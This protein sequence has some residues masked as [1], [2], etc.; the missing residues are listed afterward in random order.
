MNARTWSAR[1]D[2]GS[3]ESSDPHQHDGDLPLDELLDA[4]FDEEGRLAQIGRAGQQRTAER[5]DPRPPA[6]SPDELERAV[7]KLAEGLEAIERQ[8]AL[9]RSAGTR[10]VTLPGDE[11]LEPSELRTSRDHAVEE[12]GLERLE[13]RLQTLSRRLQQRAEPEPAETRAAPA[14]GTSGGRASPGAEPGWDRDADWRVPSATQRA[15]ATE[16]APEPRRASYDAEMLTPDK[17]FTAETKRQFAA[18]EAR[19][20]ALQHNLGDAQIEPVRRELLELLHRVEDVGRDGRS[21]AGAV[22]EVSA[23]LDQMETKLN[24]ARNL[25]GNRLSELQDRLSGIADRIGG[26]E[27]EVPGFDAL[28]QNQSAI[29]ERFDRMEGLVQHIASPEE[30]LERVDGLRRHMQAIAS[31]RDVVRIE[32]QISKLAERLDALPGDRGALERMENQ[33]QALAGE[34]VEARRQRSSGAAELNGRLAELSATLH[35][36]G[37][38][39]RA[40]DLTGLEQKLADIGSRLDDER[41]SAGAA[42]ARLEERLVA[43]GAAVEAEKADAAVEMLGG[44]SQRVEG[45]AAA[46]EAQDAPRIRGDLQSLGDKLDQLARSLDQQAERLSPRLEP[47]EARL[48]GLQTQLQT[49]SERA[50]TSTTEFGHV[51]EKVRE[52]ADRVSGGA[53]EDPDPVAAR[54][55]IIEER[56]TA[57]AARGGPDARALQTQLEAVVSRLEILKG[58]SIDPARINELFDRIDA[59]MRQELGSERFDKLEE[60]LGRAVVPSERFDQ[61]EKRLAE[62]VPAISEGQLARL[63]E[64]IDAL[65]RLPAAGVAASPAAGEGVT[66]EDIAE[67]RTD[68][69]ALR[70][71]LRS[72]PGLG[73]GEANLG[74]VLKAISARLN[75]LPEERPATAPEL[76]KQIDRLAQ[77]F[78]EPSDRRLALAHIETSLKGIE[79]RLEET[80]RTLLSRSSS[81]ADAVSGAEID[82]VTGLARALSDDVTQLKGAAEAS[83]KRNKEAIEALQGTMEAVVKRMAFLER[84][85]EPSA[86]S[87]PA[88]AEPTHGERVHATEPAA[89]PVS[90]RSDDRPV[91]AAL[92]PPVAAAM[93]P[94]SLRAESLRETSSGGLFGR[95]TSRELL[96]RAT[97]GRADSFS[98]DAD[99][100][101]ETADLPL[102]PGTDAPIKSEL[103]GAPSSDTAFMAGSRRGRAAADGD[104]D[105]VRPAHDAPERMA[106]EDFLAAARRAAKEAAAEAAQAEHEAQEARRSRGLSRVLYAMRARR[107]VLLMAA[108]LV[109]LGFAAFQLMRDRIDLGDLA[110]T[111]ISSLIAEKTSS[112]PGDTPS[113]AIAPPRSPNST[114]S[115]RAAADQTSRSASA[116]GETRIGSRPTSTSATAEAAAPSAPASTASIGKAPTA[117]AAKPAETKAVAALGTAQPQPATP[118]YT[119]AIRT[120]DRESAASRPTIAAPQQRDF[121][122]SLAMPLAPTSL[123]V[124]IGPAGLRAA[125]LAGDPVAAFEVAARFAEGRGTE[126]DPA[127]AIQWYTQAA[128]AGL[129]PAQ[130]RLGS[131]YEKG[132]GVPKDARAAAD[133]YRRAAEAGNVKAMHNLAVLYA[134]GASGAPNLARAA[135]LFR[136]A[137]RHGVRDSQFNLAILHARGLGVPVDMVE[138]YKWFAVAASS[139]DAEALKRRDV[140]GDALSEADLAKA[141]AAAAAFEPLPLISEANDVMLPEGGWREDTTSLDGDSAGDMVALVQTL[142]AQRGYDPGPADGLLGWKTIEAISLF[143]E[144]AGLPRTGEVDSSLVAALQDRPT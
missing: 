108:L 33:L 144:Q 1:R 39:G 50:E 41:R 42:L 56:L 66:Q 85:A 104:I 47:L 76:E 78:E 73:E 17:Q 2:G 103:A 138:A 44:L 142:L 22:G 15:D 60:M 19:V 48:Q 82:A 21:I 77:L 119:G 115:V 35:Q 137:A 40:P 79:A 135:E 74:A 14:R 84:D 6:L 12:G 92:Q 127:A 49:L 93:Q 128:E 4:R 113:A 98:P 96:K 20:E 116:P 71:E 10:G 109:A 87:A 70:R 27:A 65:G 91:A 62:T 89:R 26:I 107:R 54:L 101:E 123:P 80:R 124:E 3:G 9:P 105:A 69:V 29:L 52:I 141:K 24:A 46:V 63:E 139:G 121:D 68:I 97:G 51:A 13:E 16:P 28:R 129:A 59:A 11:S 106:G 94:P 34:F 131:I 95:F 117:P 114:L 45:L 88:P 8:S 86:A 111:R 102:E 130:Y 7:Q 67:L 133:W 81:D 143:Q 36:I 132:R 61:L 122:G 110:F 58:R 57:L 134:E 55:A 64:K 18:L 136:E 43:L 5:L 37:E 30:M 38:A 23:K 112:V 72:L 83:D 118:A 32:E 126:Q 25:T 90:A 100:S 53:T 99:E 125:A 120:P 31:Q 75:Q 140:I